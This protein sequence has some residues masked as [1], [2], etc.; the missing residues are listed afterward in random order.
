MIE[1]N[2]KNVK[3]K[4][5]RDYSS[6]KWKRLIVA[7]LLELCTEK[8]PAKGWE[9]VMSSKTRL[10]SKLLQSCLLLCMSKLC[11]NTTFSDVHLNPKTLKKVLFFMGN[12]VWNNDKKSL[13]SAIHGNGVT[14][15]VEISKIEVIL[16]VEYFCMEQ[17]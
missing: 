10:T 2:I 3:W 12:S 14:L 16:Y 9:F 8:V 4:T 17:K 15:W 11:N 5:T 7:S 13:F 1:G 6:I